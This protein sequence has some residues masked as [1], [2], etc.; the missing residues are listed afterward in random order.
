MPFTP[1]P[2]TLEY[3]RRR[4]LTPVTDAE[5]ALLE[6]RLGGKA[7]AS[8]VA[9]MKEFGSVEFDSDLDCQ[10]TYVYEETGERLT[11][12][13]GYIKKPE[14][15]L[16]YYEGLQGDA[17]VDLPSHLL[18]FAMDNSE[19]ELLIEFGQPTERIYYWNFDTHDWGSGVTRLGLV[20]QDMVEFIN[21]LK[22]YDG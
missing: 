20:A 7:P 4:G 13:V 17:E 22:P 15:A 10:F 12:L 3:W 11:R 14:R 9:F 16:R 8:Y 19:G 5:I 2:A 1:P 18:P 6:E 21:G